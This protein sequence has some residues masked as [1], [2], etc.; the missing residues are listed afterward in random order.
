MSDLNLHE[1]ISNHILKVLNK[2][3]RKKQAAAVLGVSEIK[4]RTLTQKYKITKKGNQFI[5]K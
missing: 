1:Y 3:K 4:L 5:K 2:E